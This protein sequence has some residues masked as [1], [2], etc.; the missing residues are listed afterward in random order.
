MLEQL[1]DDAHI[2]VIST[3]PNRYSSYQID[4]P[5]FDGFNKLTIHRDKFFEHYRWYV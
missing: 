5:E 1:P 2:D 3:Q 4:A